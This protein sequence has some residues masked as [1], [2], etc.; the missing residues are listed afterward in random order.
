MSKKLLTTV[1]VTVPEDNLEATIAVSSINFWWNF[2]FLFVQ[3]WHG[4]FG[5][6]AS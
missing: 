2:I 1:E 5:E 6:E 4:Y 3:T